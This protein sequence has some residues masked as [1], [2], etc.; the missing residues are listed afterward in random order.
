VVAAG[1][2]AAA[3]MAEGDDLGVKSSIPGYRKGV[4]EPEKET[5]A[6]RGI[7]GTQE[8]ALLR[9]TLGK[10]ETKAARGAETE[11]KARKAFNVDRAE[12]GVRR[13]SCAQ[14]PI[15]AGTNRSKVR[16]GQRDIRRCNPSGPRI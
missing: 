8:A 13:R 16:T 7:R 2:N 9:K 12:A 14:P 11:E 3:D 4:A 15:G 6:G 5:S 1:V 10:K